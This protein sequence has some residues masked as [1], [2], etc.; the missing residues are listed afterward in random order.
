MN[1]TTLQAK[2]SPAMFTKFSFAPLAA[3]GIAR[4]TN[5]PITVK[6]VFS[7]S[8]NEVNAAAFGL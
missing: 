5:L 2:R 4:F 6:S 3:V 1:N 8:L 7:L